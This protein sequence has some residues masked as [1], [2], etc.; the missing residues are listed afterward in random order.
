MSPASYFLIVLAAVGCM[1]IGRLLIPVSPSGRQFIAGLTV[2]AG[3]SASLAWFA[4]LWILP[5]SRLA[6]VAGCGV[7]L[8]GARKLFP[9]AWRRPSGLTI[10]RAVAAVVLSLSVTLVLHYRFAEIVYA[11][12][13]A[14]QL[15]E[16]FKADYFGPLRIPSYYPWETAGSHIVA[17]TVIS[18]LGALLPEG[19]MLAGMEIQFLLLTFIIARFLFIALGPI[20]P[21]ALTW[22]LP[23]LAAALIVFHYEYSEAA[24]TTT[25]W[26]W[27]LSLELG[28]IIFWEEGDADRR[29]RDA[30]FLLA[31]MV[32]AKTS[33]IYLP[34]LAFAWVVFRFP[35]QAVH[36]SVI[37]CAVITLAQIVT[38]ATRPFPFPDVSIGL[39]L[40]HFGDRAALDWYYPTIRDALIRPEMVQSLFSHHYVVGIFVVL[41]LVL[42]KYWIIPSKAIDRLIREAPA[43]REF[44][45]TAE[46]VLL[47]ALIGWLVM[48]HDQ[49]GITHQVGVYYGTAPMIMAALLR[50]AV[51]PDGRWWRLGLV[52]AAAWSLA[53]GYNPWSTFNWPSSP[54]LGGVTHTE[55]ARMSEAELLASR[56]GDSVSDPCTRALLRGFRV[57]AGTVPIRCASTLGALAVEPKKR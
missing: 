47:I 42:V 30:L 43:N 38:T 12:Y 32:A 34:S 50:R 21:A 31:A 33:I 51:L 6:V 7:V 44:F 36:P 48:R 26:Y 27:I 37:L 17:P 20:R 54:H 16:I 2:I 10:A 23:I 11:T 39:S 13:F 8:I 4:P 9:I 53:S 57:P 40:F 5:F 22:A 35:R 1:G 41:A 45:R 52:A 29:A 19:T 24:Q 3:V 25:W 55:L 28:I 18:T 49:H 14:G 46:V 56:P 15:V